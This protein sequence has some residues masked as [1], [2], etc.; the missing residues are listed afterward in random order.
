[1]ASTTV[2]SGRD[3]AHI[4]ALLSSP[5]IAGLIAQLQLTRWTG[6]PGYPLCAMV[7]LALVKGVDAL[8]TWTRAVNLVR[9]HAALRDVLGAAPSDDAAHRFTRKLREHNAP[10]ASCL[11]ET[12]AAL[13]GLKP[14]MGQTIAIDG[15]DL[16]AYA[17]GHKH[18]GNKNGPLRTRFADPDAGW[19][20]RSSIS[21]RKGGAYYGY[22]IHASVCTATDL[23]LAWTVE[24]ANE[25]ETEQVPGLLN[26]TLA[27]G[28][29][30][31]AGV[32]DK[33]YDG[34]PMYDVCESRGIRP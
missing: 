2:T 28:F 20:H 5:E 29:T 24:A 31:G 23:P 11:E 14:E 7:G 30:P 3:A 12:L 33:G 17:N 18:V 26:T 32:L 34:Q 22:K 9:D 25:P 27:R 10:L 4:R 15:S 13:H 21:T 8:P 19:G 1:V 16:P 6:R